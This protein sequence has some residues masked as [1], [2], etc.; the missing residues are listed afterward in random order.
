MKP[1]T[2]KHAQSPGAAPVPKTRPRI[3]GA[4]CNI[5]PEMLEDALLRRAGLAAGSSC[6]VR[7]ERSVA[8][9]EADPL[10]PYT[11]SRLDAF[12]SL[13]ECAV[14]TDSGAVR[15]GLRRIVAAVETVHKSAEGKGLAEKVAAA[16]YVWSQSVEPAQRNA[17]DEMLGPLVLRPTAVG[18]KYNKILMDRSPVSIVGRAPEAPPGAGVGRRILAAGA[19]V[20][21]AG[22]APAGPPLAGAGRQQ[23]VLRPPRAR[24]TPSSDPGV[25]VVRYVIQHRDGNEEP[26]EAVPRDLHEE[27]LKGAEEKMVPKS[28]MPKIIASIVVGLT[29]VFGGVAIKCFP[30]LKIA[31]RFQALTVSQD[32]IKEKM[33][34]AVTKNDEVTI[35]SRHVINKKGHQGPLSLQQIFDIYDYVAGEVAYQ[36]DS[37]PLFPQADYLTLKA[38]GGDCKSKSVLLA[39]M[40]EKVGAKT[41][42]ILA[43]YIRGDGHAYV[44][45]Q[46]SN[47]D[48]STEADRDGMMVAAEIAKRYKG[49][50][51]ARFGKSEHKPVFRRLYSPGLSGTY[52]VLDASVMSQNDIIP[53]MTIDTPV[54]REIE[55]WTTPG[56]PGNIP[57]EIK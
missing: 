49:N 40:L 6:A 17:V 20:S 53:G 1:L 43:D 31:E 4:A 22:E 15:N 33:R 9:F 52:L 57:E 7:I 28:K 47:K 48:S 19:E 34:N 26:L 30:E 54:R 10:G 29:L 18:R 3:S 2:E 38:K 5:P 16:I 14:E 39:S 37:H 23:G 11:D 55:V 45:V 12:F 27:M 42:I 13:A 24:G 46:I 44:I 8:A 50:I 41:A 51:A 21:I 35:Q 36:S 32:T 25:S 56:I